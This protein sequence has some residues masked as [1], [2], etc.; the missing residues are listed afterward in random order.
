MSAGWKGLFTR[1]PRGRKRLLVV[2]HDPG[3]H[4]RYRL[5]VLLLIVG[6]GVACFYL[7]ISLA[8]KELG[9]LRT[10]LVHTK[11][12]NSEQIE[13]L[14]TLRRK[15]VILE[16]SAWI[17]REAAED[18]RL[19]L[20]K[21]REEKSVLTRD[22]SFFRSIMD[23][24]SLEEGVNVQ[25]FELQPLTEEGKFQWKF[26]VVQNA[27]QHRVQKGTFKVRVDGYLGD[28]KKSYDLGQLSSD[29][30]D[31]GQVLSFRYFQSVPGEGV[32]GTLELPKGFEP[33][34]LEVSVQLTSPSRKIIK[35]TLEWFVEESE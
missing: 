22:L 15:V 9:I 34:I 12:D 23:P 16:R 26:M 1:Y 2:D 24:G 25:N 18:V 30:S 19:E 27:K 4:L 28:I 32:W 3:R 11:A 21:L 31:N 8:G 17:N 13:E 33:E 10:E 29:M 6:V 14:D 5:L 7:G 35:K 20:M